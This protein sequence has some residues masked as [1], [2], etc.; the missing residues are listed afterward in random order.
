MTLRNSIWTS[1]NTWGILEFTMQKRFQCY[2]S[3]WRNQECFDR[4]RSCRSASLDEKVQPLELSAA[5]E[6]GEITEG[7]SNI[8]EIPQESTHSTEQTPTRQSIIQRVLWKKWWTQSMCSVLEV[9]ANFFD[10]SNN[11]V[12]SHEYA[13]YDTQSLKWCELS[14]LWRYCKPL[15]DWKLCESIT[16]QFSLA[17]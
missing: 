15:C 16:L 5:E 1:K 11:R 2:S 14:F 13:H 12:W 10:C 8:Q 17:K 9:W 6:I 7:A 4:S 3:A